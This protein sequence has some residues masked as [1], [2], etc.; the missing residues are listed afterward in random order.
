MKVALGCDHAGLELKN[1][2]ITLLN[3]LGIKYQDFGAYEP[4]SCDYSDYAIKVSELVAKG[5]YD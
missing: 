3:E 1:Q 4:V 5:E 2:I